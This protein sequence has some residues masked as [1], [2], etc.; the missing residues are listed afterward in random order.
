MLKIANKYHCSARLK[1][2]TKKLSWKTSRLCEI[3]EWEND[4]FIKV[5]KEIMG[6][7]SFPKHRKVW[8]FSATILALK[9]LN[10]LNKESTCISV[11]AG[12]ERILFYLANQIA[13]V[14][15]T[16]IYGQ[17]D[18]ADKEADRNFINNQKQFAPYNY[19]ENNLIA[20]NCNALDLKFPDNSFDF[21]FSMSS[22]EHFGGVKNANKA[23]KEM[24]RVVKPGGI[25]IVS[26]EFAINNFK[27]DQVF[28]YKDFNKLIK[29]TG[30]KNAGP[31]PSLDFSLSEESLEHLCDMLVDDLGAL[32]HLNLK[33]YA[34][35]FTSAILILR[36]DGKSDKRA[37]KKKLWEIAKELRHEVV[38]KKQNYLII[39]I[40]EKLI[41]L[42]LKVD[43][44][45]LKLLG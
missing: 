26:T 15:A 8:E 29:D 40:K 10:L 18:F 43:M 5:A 19:E 27:T 23:L 13:G 31:N 41:S 39:K 6:N 1:K 12:V 24:S 4:E 9:E 38:I 35:I 17:G 21:A 44:K 25:V 3:N 16:D 7:N 34:S 37:N 20:A 36:K 11:A 32:P 28:K 14:I 42:K 30:L 2:R 45:L 22:I 33:A